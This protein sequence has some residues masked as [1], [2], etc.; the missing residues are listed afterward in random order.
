MT[1]RAGARDR[2]GE[3]DPEHFERFCRVI[4]PDFLTD[5]CH[6]EEELAAQVG[7]DILARGNPSRRLMT[8]QGMC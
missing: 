2:Q 6:V 8:R 4:V 1:V 3:P 5:L 7:E